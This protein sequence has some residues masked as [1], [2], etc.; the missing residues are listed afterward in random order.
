MWVLEY[1]SHGSHNAPRPHVV[2]PSSH[3]IL[4]SLHLVPQE[5][6]RGRCRETPP[7]EP[8]GDGRIVARRQS[9]RLVGMLDMH[10]HGVVD[11]GGEALWAR[12]V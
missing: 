9:V 7:H 6:V 12:G 3:T 5:R 2:P 8:F 4:P 1:R 10:G 11:T